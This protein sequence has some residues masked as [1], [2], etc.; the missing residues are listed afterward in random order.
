[1]LH[2]KL[3]TLEDVLFIVDALSSADYNLISDVS[4]EEIIYHKEGKFIL[5]MHI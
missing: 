4:K 3:T 2:V 5:C 1:M